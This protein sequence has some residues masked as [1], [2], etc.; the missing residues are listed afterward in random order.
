MASYDSVSGDKAGLMSAGDKHKLDN[1]NVGYGTCDTAAST[2]AKIVTLDS[3]ATWK[4]RAGSVVAVKFTYAVPANSTLN[5]NSMGAK[6]IYHNGAKIIAG[7]IGAGDIATFIYDGTNYVLLV[8]DSSSCIA[9]TSKKGLMSAADK[10]KLNNLKH[11]YETITFKE[12]YYCNNAGAIINKMPLDDI[13]QM[14][15]NYCYNCPTDTYFNGENSFKLIIRPENSAGAEVGP[16]YAMFDVFN[17]YESSP[18]YPDATDLQVIGFSGF[19]NTA[20]VNSSNLNGGYCGILKYDGNEFIERH[21]YN[22]GLPNA[23]PGYATCATAPSTTAK[24]ATCANYSLVTGGIV[25]VKFTYAVPANSTLNINSKGAK[26]IYHKGAAIKSNVISANSV[27]VFVYD[28]SYYVLLSVDKM[29]TATTST[30]GLMSAA[31]KD[32]LNNLCTIITCPLDFGEYT[33]DGGDLDEE[34]WCHWWDSLMGELM[35]FGMNNNTGCYK[36]ILK[37][38]APSRWD[39]YNTSIMTLDVTVHSD[40][41]MS[42]LGLI[43]ETCVP[44]HNGIR[45]TGYAGI[46]GTWQQGGPIYG[47]VDAGNTVVSIKQMGSNWVFNYEPSGNY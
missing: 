23:T 8:V 42:I 46:T 9:T 33:N 43:N 25:T 4:M 29:P 27:A 40:D 20:A 28:G 24:T 11:N 31:D 14:L 26:S 13:F 45:S 44:G 1:T 22:L 16:Y 21:I 2:A 15:A 19:V 18:C 37:G 36:V 47:L 32:K 5:I 39:S 34:A 41:T 35:A 30:E 17:I 7:V 3:A 38:S 6:S 12:P 10:T